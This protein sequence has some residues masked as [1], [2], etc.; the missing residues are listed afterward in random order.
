MM[1]E[2]GGTEK[3]FDLL[4]GRRPE[5]RPRTSSPTASRPARSGSRSRSPSSASWSPRS[6]ATTARSRRCRT[7]RRSTTATTCSTPVEPAS[8]PPLLPRPSRSPPRPSAT[9]PPTPPR[10]RSIA[11]AGRHREAPGRSPAASRRSRRPCAVAHQEAGPQA[12]RRRGPA[13]RRPRPHATCARCRPRSASCRRPTA[14]ACSSG[15]RPR[16]STSCTLAMP[17][18]N[19]LLDTLAPGDAPSATCTTTTWRRGPTVR[20]AASV[21]RSAARSATARSPSG[22]C[23]PSCPARRSSPTR[24]ASC[25]RCCRPTAPPRWRRCAPSSLSLMDAGVPVKAPVAGIAMGLVYADGKYTTL[26]DIL[27]A[28]DAF[29]DM[30][31]K[32]AGTADVRHRAAARHQDRR[33]PRRRA[34]RRPRPGPGR[35]HSQILDVMNARHRRAARPRWARRRRRSRQLHRSRWT[36][37]ARSSG[38]RAR[39]STPIQQET[40][41]D[42][43]VDD[44][45]VGR[46]RHHRLRPTA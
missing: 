17:R 30:D 25:P 27:G 21:R 24:C 16:C 19:Q 20:P 31:F 34:G 38:P 37:S 46:H 39:S 41:A 28:E 7:R 18:M 33:H 2:A 12:D 36:R 13:H 8:P 35:P 9:R 22:R 42:I 4:R 15:A 40:G 14:R 11:D 44:D 5:G 29:G 43:A 45:G 3:A 1:V 32:V 26:T 6:V 10:P 23:C